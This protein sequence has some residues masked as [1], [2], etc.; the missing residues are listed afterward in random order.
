MTKR[1]QTVT[2]EEK[3]EALESH[4]AITLKPVTPSKEIVQ[5]LRARIHMPARDE[6]ILRLSDWRRLFLVFGGVLSGMMLLIT[7]ARAFYY[8]VGRRDPM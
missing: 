6:I 8:L 5:R 7:I 4:L 1:K 2:P 3:L